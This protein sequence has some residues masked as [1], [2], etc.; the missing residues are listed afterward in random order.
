MT[1]SGWHPYKYCERQV[2]DQTLLNSVFRDSW[3]PLPLRYNF[4]TKPAN[5]RASYM[6]TH[7]ALGREAA[8]LHFAG[9]HKPWGSHHV[10]QPYYR[11]PWKSFH[12]W[13]HH[14]CG[15]ISM[16]M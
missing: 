3:K 11:Q 4:L 14:A 10:R 16:S 8:I 9:D 15:A 6:P 12:D 7:I 13:W 2:S 1:G 5:T